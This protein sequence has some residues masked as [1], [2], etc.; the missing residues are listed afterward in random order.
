MNKTQYVKTGDIIVAYSGNVLIQGIKR[1][2]NFNEDIIFGCIQDGLYMSN[3]TV[4]IYRPRKEY[5]KVERVQ[6]KEFILK[7]SKAFSN[8]ELIFYAVNTIRRDTFNMN[9]KI[10]DLKT[11]KYYHYICD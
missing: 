9:F 11:N 4:R 7:N 5:S 3:R 2:C 1:L 6:F 8:L 10:N